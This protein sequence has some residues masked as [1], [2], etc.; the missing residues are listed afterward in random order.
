MCSFFI[1]EY[2]VHCRKHI[3]LFRVFVLLQCLIQ[4]GAVTKNA[5]FHSLFLPKKHDMIWKCAV[6]KTTLSFT[7][8]LGDSTQLQYVCYTVSAKHGAIVTFEYPAKFK[9]V[10]RQCWIYCVAYLFVNLWL[11][12]AI[13]KLKTD[14]ENLVHMYLRMC[15]FK[16]T[17]AYMHDPALRGKAQIYHCGPH[18]WDGITKGGHVCR[19]RSGG[20]VHPRNNHQSQIYL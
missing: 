12:D 19:T 8:V 7:H 6:K 16:C 14:F 17:H 3:T 11:D 18:P 2:T 1:S 9:K 4:L 13:I 20:G 10:F 5:E 15:I